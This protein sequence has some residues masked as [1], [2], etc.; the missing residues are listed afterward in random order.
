V[1]CCRSGAR[2]ASAQNMLSGQ[3]IQS[4]NAGSWQTVETALKN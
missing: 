1:L 3:G 2:A 4:I